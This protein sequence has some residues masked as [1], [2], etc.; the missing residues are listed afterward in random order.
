M[1]H[2]ENFATDGVHLGV[3]LKTENTVTEID[4]GGT[5]VLFHDLVGAL[6]N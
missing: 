1:H 3:E 6:E 5:A 2:G 4:H